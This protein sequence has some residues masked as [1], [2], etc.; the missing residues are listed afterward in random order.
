MRLFD[1]AAAEYDAARPT[2]PDGVFDL[3]DSL[4]GGLPGR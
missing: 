4:V 1:P 2:Y 3:L